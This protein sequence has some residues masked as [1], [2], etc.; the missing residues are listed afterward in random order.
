MPQVSVLVRNMDRPTP[1]RA[2]DSIARQD[3]P[4]IEV[5][6]YF[7]AWRARSSEAQ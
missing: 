1:Q 7:K 2:L 4:R 6:A 3:D 5:A